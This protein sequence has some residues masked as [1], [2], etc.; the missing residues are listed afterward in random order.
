MTMVNS[1]LEGLMTYQSS[2]VIKKILLTDCNQ[3]NISSTIKLIFGFTIW[4]TF[5]G[6]FFKISGNSRLY[7]YIIW[8]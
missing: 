6:L 1:G 8:R 4:N 5:M 3:C 2:K 7:S